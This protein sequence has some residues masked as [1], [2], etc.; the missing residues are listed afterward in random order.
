[1]TIVAGSQARPL[2]GGPL[3]PAAGRPAMG[4]V[5]G[6]EA[7]VL[8][9][10]DFEPGKR[11]AGGQCLGRVGDGDVVAQPGQGNAHR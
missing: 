6:R 2:A 5:G 11:Q 10:L 8:D 7:D 4:C 3:R 1:M 9:V